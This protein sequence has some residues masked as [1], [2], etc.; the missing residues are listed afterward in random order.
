M[1]DSTCGH[2]A[3]GSEAAA[4]ALLDALDARVG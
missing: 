2:L 4:V 1:I 3:Q